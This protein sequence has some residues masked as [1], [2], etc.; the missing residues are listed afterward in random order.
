MMNSRERFL[1]ALSAQPL[2]RPPVWVMRQAGRYL[3]EYRKLKES[4]DFRT[5]VKTPDLA[6]EVTLQ[7][8][9]RYPLDAA[10]LFSDILIIPE[11]LGQDYDFRDGGGIEMAF[12]LDSPDQ[13]D[14]ADPKVL[15]SKFHYISETLDRLR[16]ELGERKALLGF[17]GSPWTLA[18][19]MIE[20]GSS[21]SFRDL[22]RWYWTRPDDFNRLMQNLSDATAI[23][24][25]LMIESGVDAVQIFDSWGSA[26]GGA[27]Y[28]D[29]SLRW[30][31]KV[32]EQLPEGFPVIVFAKGMA[33]HASSLIQTGARGLSVD[34]T[35]N[36]RALRD[37]LPAETVLQG[38]LDPLLLTLE[39]SV[40]ARQT[41]RLLESMRG[42]RGHIFNLGH[43]ITPDARMDSM[44][45][46]LATITGE[47]VCG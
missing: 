47:D 27:E 16:G 20:G 39:P 24:L 22:L 13:I 14:Q 26:C 33:H 41:T 1:R 32:I 5:M 11:A 44:A 4:H 7:P 28:H 29:Q 3:P 15:R 6:V 25:N 40:V 17:A 23:L 42:T 18:S 35:V 36:L 19:Y 38:N 2:D 43:G 8:M 34:S 37:Q 21:R 45:A 30:I 9:R 10:I 46:M 31:R 12:S